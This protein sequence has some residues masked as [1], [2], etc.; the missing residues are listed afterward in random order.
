MYI[1][2]FLST[3]NVKFTYQN[4]LHR[5]IILGYAGVFNLVTL[6]RKNREHFWPEAEKKTR[7][8]YC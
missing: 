1:Q 3:T 5:E 8:R 7:Q 2:K 6:A 4:V